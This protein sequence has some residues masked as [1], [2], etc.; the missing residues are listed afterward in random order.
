MAQASQRQV[1]N[2]LNQALLEF[3]N[4]Q[5]AQQQALAAV[6]AQQV[7]VNAATV[8]DKFTVP[9]QNAANQTAADQALA[10][11][12]A[13]FQGLFQAASDATVVLNAAT[14]ALQKAITDSLSSPNVIEQV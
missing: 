2:P 5:V 13:R 7:V 11:D 1:M 4:A 12:Q 9:A 3:E 10:N 14:A 8:Y 6:A